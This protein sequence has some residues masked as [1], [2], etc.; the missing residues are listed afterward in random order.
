MDI[1]LQDPLSIKILLGQAIINHS[2]A[3]AGTTL[4]IYQLGGGTR[5]LRLPWSLSPA[6]ACLCQTAPRR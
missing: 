3:E 6:P 4:Y 2:M 5:Q 1:P